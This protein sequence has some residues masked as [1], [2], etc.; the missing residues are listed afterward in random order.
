MLSEVSSDDAAPSMH[1]HYACV[2]LVATAHFRSP[3]CQEQWNGHDTR[4][5]IEHIGDVSSLSPPHSLLV[6]IPLWFVDKIS[7]IGITYFP[8]T[9][10]SSVSRNRAAGVY[11]RDSLSLAEPKSYF[12]SSFSWNFNWI[13]NA[14]HFSASN[15]CETFLCQNNRQ[16]WPFSSMPCTRL[17]R[18][19]SLTKDDVIENP[20]T[21]VV[22]NLRSHMSFHPFVVA[23]RKEKRIK[24]QK[25]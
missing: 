23:K 16:R 17:M 8:I 15:F 1:I 19:Y 24:K 20:L 22:L 12:E 4:R 2:F 10:C 3:P 21:S 13:Q 14:T 11:W 7:R 6:E 25:H 18:Y 9:T 5:C